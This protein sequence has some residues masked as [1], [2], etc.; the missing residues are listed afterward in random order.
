MIWLKTKLIFNKQSFLKKLRSLQWTA[1]GLY[2]HHSFTSSTR[3]SM[4]T[5]NCQLSSGHEVQLWS[6]QHSEFYVC[7]PQ[8]EKFLKLS[9]CLPVWSSDVVYCVWDNICL[10]QIP[11]RYASLTSSNKSITKI[12]G[13]LFQVA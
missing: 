13:F 1:K 7:I 8:A 12:W 9:Y 6:Y 4:M 11:V 10:A 5:C 3:V 2:N